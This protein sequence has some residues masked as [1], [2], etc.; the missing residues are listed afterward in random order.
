M[1]PV[2]LWQVLV[3]CGRIYHMRTITCPACKKE[4]NLYARNVCESCYSK[5]RPKRECKKCGKK[6]VIKAWELCNACYTAKNIKTRL[7]KICIE[8][9]R[10]DRVAKKGLCRKCYKHEWNQKN[11]K[12]ILEY[13]KQW[14]A[15]HPER[16][17]ATQQKYNATPNG[18][19]VN[20][21]KVHKRLDR[22]SENGVDGLT[23]K[24]WDEIK[25]EH[26]HLCYY[27]GEKKEL[28][29]EHKIPVSRGGKFEKENIVPSCKLCN[30]KKG[31]MTE[32]EFLTKTLDQSI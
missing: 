13:S 9:G 14:N 18:K 5:I 4:K 27:C 11:M 17:K 29:I 15:E 30:R 6:R 19:I 23:P 7:P 28:E 3:V 26:N 20:L 1:A 10:V 16:R 8:C 25:Q 2:L 24:E 12:H 22:I 32:K 31:T 21:L